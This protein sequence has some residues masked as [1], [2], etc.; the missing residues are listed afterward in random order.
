MLL[1]AVVR[2]ERHFIRGFV[3]S[4]QTDASRHIEI[5]YLIID[6]NKSNIPRVG[7]PLAEHLPPLFGGGFRSVTETSIG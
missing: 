5:G 3:E 6:G 2:Q 4:G 1:E 7:K